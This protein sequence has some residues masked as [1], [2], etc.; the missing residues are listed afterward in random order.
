MCDDEVAALVVDNG[1]YTKKKKTK[2]LRKLKKKRKTELKRSLLLTDRNGLSTY[3]MWI[4][5]YFED[6][7]C[8]VPLSV[9]QSV[10]ES[11]E[12]SKFQKENSHRNIYIKYFPYNNFQHKFPRKNCDRFQRVST[13]D[14]SI[15]FS[16][17]FYICSR[18]N[19]T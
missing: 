2:K 11:T 7:Q 1:A 16:R 18:L 9:I 6:I 10:K 8:C 3:H 4:I 14:H 12:N 13:Q 15:K 19:S 17:A 5:N